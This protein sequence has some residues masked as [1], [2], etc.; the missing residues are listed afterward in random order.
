MYAPPNVR[1]GILGTGNMASQFA[2]GLARLPD[3]RLI[4]VAS[5]QQRRAEA[6]GD[7]AGV[8]HRHGSYAALLED[9]DVDVVYVAT[10]HTE[11]CANTL[12]ALRAGKHVLVEKPF[13][14][15]AA[16]AETM[17]AEARQ[18]G[19]FVME[20]TWMRFLPL[21]GEL[22]RLLAEG[23]IGAPRM[24]MADFGFVAPFNPESRLFNPS[25]GGGSLLDVGIYPVSLA[26]LVFGMPTAIHSLA[27][28]GKTG[29]DEQVG[30]LLGY[31]GGEIALLASATRTETA[32]EAT[33][34]GEQ[35]RIRIHTRWWVPEIMTVTVG[36][37]QEV[38]HRPMIGNGYGHEAAEVMRCLHAGL[39][40][41]PLM[42]LDETLTI[43]RMLDQIRAQ[44]GL[45][46]P[47]E[48]PARGHAA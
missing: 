18:R 48:R 33:I 41:S 24:L 44:W 14:L 17:I 40:E 46:Y 34:C 15:N 42:P 28:L 31:P 37:K 39:T 29:V 20:A 3:A 25:L 35:G 7:G 4:A 21:M 19:L 30:V 10:P 16:E 6:F 11:H 2:M 47:S 23:T 36:V 13:A 26:S 1:W 12:A 43:M 5:R 27:H 38:I 45:V 22:R 8:P 32:Q 9:P